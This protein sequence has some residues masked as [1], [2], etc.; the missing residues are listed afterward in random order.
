MEQDGVKKRG[1]AIRRYPNVLVQRTLTKELH[2]NKN[3]E[4]GRWP[5]RGRGSGR[6]EM[7]G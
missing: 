1:H 7:G 4:K 3:G 2:G 6:L 5:N